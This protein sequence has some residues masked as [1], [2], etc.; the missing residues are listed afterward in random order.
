M[1]STELIVVGAGVIGLTTALTL[2]RAGVNVRILADEDW[3]TSCSG[4]AAAF[5]YPY[6]ANPLEKVEKWGSFSLSQFKRL[7]QDEASGVSIHSMLE[8]SIGQKDIPWWASI[9]D[10]FKA[11]APQDLPNGYTSGFWFDTPI[12]DTSVYMP[13]LLKEVNQL[14]GTIERQRL[15]NW[16]DLKANQKMVVN[17]TGIGSKQLCQDDDLKPAKGQVLRIKRH[18]PDRAILDSDGEIR[19]AHI[20]PRTHDTVIGG[21]YFENDSDL[22]PLT[23]ETEKI[24]ARCKLLSPG[25]NVEETDILGVNCG[26]RPVRSSVRLETEDM[27]NNCKVIHNYGHG[28]A[29]YTLSWGC[30]A[31]VCELLDAL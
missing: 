17:C 21:I 5:W 26:L 6:H 28:G 8:V 25:F 15:N 27:E 23:T 20:T 29:G 7:A 12:I 4:A 11:A 14:G 1:K 31:E 22:T 13:F 30:A 24:I 18:G 2:L 10:N 9:V 3:Q 19:F 16:S